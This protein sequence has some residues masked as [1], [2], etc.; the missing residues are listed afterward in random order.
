MAI[1]ASIA[2]GLSY[3]LAE[4][5]LGWKNTSVVWV[6]IAFLAIFAWFPQRKLSSDI[7]EDINRQFVSETQQKEKKNIWKS[8]LAWYLTLFMGFQ[9]LNYYSLTAWI[10]SILQGDGMSPETAGYMAFWYQ[11]IGIPFSFITPILASRVKKP[12]DYRCLQ[13]HR[14]FCRI[15][16]PTGLSFQCSS[17]H[18]A[19]VSGKRRHCQL[20][21]VYGNGEFERRMMAKKR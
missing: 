10:P 5:G 9:S 7:S 18:L 3:P 21:L 19:Y 8:P 11:L 14:L 15:G 17:D 13:L 4:A 16:R 1:F 6:G 2:S 12:D 20:Q